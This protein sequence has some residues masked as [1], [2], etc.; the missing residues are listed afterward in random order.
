MYSK[1]KLKPSKLLIGIILMLIHAISMSAVT[2]IA[3]RL[4]KVISGDQIAFLYKAGVLFCTIPLMF[5]GS[6]VNNLKTSKLKLH[7]LR[8]VFSL[9]GSVCFY[10]GLLHVPATDATAVTYLE[11]IIGLIVGVIYF[12]EK[13]SIKKILLVTL[14]LS[15][16]LFIIRPGFDNFNTHYIYLLGALLFWAMNNLGIKILGKTE[17]TVT[18]LFYVSLFTTIFASPL[19]MKHSWDGFTTD[20]IKHVV[21]ITIFHMTHMICFYRALKITDMSAVMPFDYTRLLFTGVLSYLFL[22]EYPNKYSAIGYCLIAAGGLMLILYETKKRG[23]SRE[24]EEKFIR[25]KE[26]HTS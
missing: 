21:V 24:S 9:G 25:E 7:M 19:T 4:G 5:Q 17:K 18:S 26:K 16:V 22:G 20:Y 15:G 1:K 2:V 14:C 23:W 6:F 10:R 3:K 8:A 12:G 11:P 13:V